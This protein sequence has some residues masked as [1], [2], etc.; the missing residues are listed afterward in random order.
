ENANS[1]ALRNHRE[2]M[3]LEYKFIAGLGMIFNKEEQAGKII[4]EMQETVKDVQSRIRGRRKPK[5]MIVEGLGKNLV[6]YDDSK[7]AGDICT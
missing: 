6:A 4:A 3:E 7:L 1:P 2:S 5:V